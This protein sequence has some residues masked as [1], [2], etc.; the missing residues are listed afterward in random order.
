MEI[1]FDSIPVLEALYDLQVSSNNVM[2]QKVV[3]SHNFSKTMDRD[4][5]T[6][7][8]SDILSLIRDGITA[9]INK[10]KKLINDCVMTLNSYTMEYNKLVEKY[11]SMLKSKEFKPFEIEGFNFITLDV[12]K[13]DGSSVY[14]IIEDF[15][16][17]I[18]KFNRYTSE[19]IREICMNAVSPSAFNNIRGK[20]LGNNKNIQDS[21]F[22]EY[23][24]SYYRNGMTQPSMITVD[25][26]YISALID[27]SGKLL[28]EK[29]STKSEKDYLMGILGRMEK[30]FSVKVASLYDD[31][32]K[33]YSVPSLM[34]NGYSEDDAQ[35]IN[36]SRLNDLINYM[37]MRYQ[38]TVMLS[39]IVSLVYIERMSAIKDQINQDS[40]CLRLAIRRFGV[41]SENESLVNTSLEEC[42]TYPPTPNSNWAPI[43]EGVITI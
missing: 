17:D 39:N 13:P 27:R 30:F 36:E 25:P 9:F 8:V 10:I 14:K 19:D 35:R 2:K 4:I 31:V 41:V 21:D 28:S 15:N 42:N 38:Q 11:G 16:D 24:Y 33:T 18:S 3:V 12:N 40:Q 5:L 32:Q 26:Q 1:L 6:E 7:G 34:K 37:M 22:G 23:V 20:V 43:L 29:K